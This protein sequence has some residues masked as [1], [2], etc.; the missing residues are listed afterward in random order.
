MFADKK[1]TADMGFY[2]HFFKWPLVFKVLLWS[3]HKVLYLFF[4]G[5]DVC[6]C[7]KSLSTCKVPIANF[8]ALN[9]ALQRQNIL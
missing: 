3:I 8:S 4:F 7:T 2:Q 1:I 6:T 5:E 9:V